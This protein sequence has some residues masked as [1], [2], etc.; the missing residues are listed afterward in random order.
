MKD[1]ISMDKQAVIDALGWYVESKTGRKCVGPV[2]IDF[3]WETD[4]KGRHTGNQTIHAY[5][6]VK[7]AERPKFEGTVPRD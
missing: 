3:M 7:E 1:V 4:D 6:E 5:V 2:Q